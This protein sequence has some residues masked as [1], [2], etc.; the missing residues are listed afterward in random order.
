MDQTFYEK[1]FRPV[2]LQMA[3]LSYAHVKKTT[4]TD[5]QKKLHSVLQNALPAI[6]RLL[7]Y[8]ELKIEKVIDES[9]STGTTATK[10]NTSEPEEKVDDFEPPDEKTVQILQQMDAESL[11]LL[12][13]VKEE[14]WIKAFENFDNESYSSEPDT[15]VPEND[16]PIE[17]VPHV[18]VAACSS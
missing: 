10:P 18:P 6:E 2:F 12:K 15:S 4:F 14:M 16:K 11:D 5:E 1:Y 13:N 8:P 17:E 7:K 9:T 3:A